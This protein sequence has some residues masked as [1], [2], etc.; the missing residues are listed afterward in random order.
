MAGISEKDGR[1]LVDLARRALKYYFR[2]GD[3]LD[4]KPSEVP[5][6]ILTED[7]ACFV[8][9]YKNNELRGCIGSL[10]ASRA[11]VFDVVDNALSA[12]LNDPR[13]HPVTRDELD[14]IKIEVSVLTKPEKIDVKTAE[15]LLEKLVPRKHGM[16]VKKGWA[17]ATFLPMVWEQIPD[18]I[19]FLRHLCMKAS[20]MPD[21]WKNVSEMEFFLYEALEFHE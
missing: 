2:K 6:K 16:I 14:N 15:E 7:G 3:R 8:T 5:N 18:K 12:A 17:R 13:F 9:L 21:D 4:I 19:E 1:F 20:L 11:L 10:E